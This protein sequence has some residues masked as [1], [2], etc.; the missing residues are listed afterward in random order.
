MRVIQMSRIGVSAVALLGIGILS[1]CATRDTLS[2]RIMAVEQNI[3]M[4]KEKGAEVYAPEVLQ[5]AENKLSD[6]RSAVSAGQLV[7]ASKLLDEAMSDAEY[8]QIKAPT[9]K[10]KKEV[11]ALFEEIKNLRDEISRMSAAK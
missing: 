9:E 4:A 8:A 6:A 2:P 3:G 5:S 10:G 11:A 1:G 7:K